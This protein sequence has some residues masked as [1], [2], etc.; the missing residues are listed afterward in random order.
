MRVEEPEPESEG[1][2]VETFDLEFTELEVRVSFQ[3]QTIEDLDDEV[4]QTG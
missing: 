3:Q 1:E 2:P 4:D